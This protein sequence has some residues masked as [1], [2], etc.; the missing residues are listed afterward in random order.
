MR[1]GLDLLTTMSSPGLAAELRGLADDP[2]PDVRM[3]VLAA[4]AA[5]GDE[6]ARAAAGGRNPY[7]HGLDCPRPSGCERLRP[8]RRSTRGPSRSQASWRTRTWPS[9]ARRSSRCRPATRLPWRPAV[10]AL[11]IHARP[12]PPRERSVGSGT[13][14]CPRWRRCSRARGRRPSGRDA[15][16]S[17]GRHQV[18]RARRDP[19]PARRAPGSRARRDR[20][21]APGRARTG[22]RSDRGGARGVLLRTF[23]MPAGS[24]AP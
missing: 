12:E 10:A 16:R 13:P 1:L 23:A 11:G 7:Q 20:H 19:P 18:G 5:S 4:L 14:S 22:R 17:G 2:R 3:S 6:H 15:S 8:S 24:W 9:G 21:R